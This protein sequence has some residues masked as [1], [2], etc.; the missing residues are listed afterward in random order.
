MDSIGKRIDKVIKNSN[1]SQK[2]FAEKIG[3]S[4]QAIG[5][6]INNRRFPKAEI[7]LKMKQTFNVSVDWLLT[8]KNDT[9]KKDTN[10]VSEPREVYKATPIVE[11]SP[12][13]KANC[14]V[15]DVKASAGFGSLM[16]SRT[17]LEELPAISLLNA[18]F[19]LNVA[20]QIEGDSM[21]NTIRHLDYVA[22]NHI[23]DIK[24]IKDGH[25]YIIIEKGN[26]PT[27]KR[28]YKEKGVFRIV[29]D[30]PTY[31]EYILGEK[32]IVAIF[33][34]FQRFSSDFRNYFDEVRTDVNELK[35]GFKE[36]KKQF[37]SLER[38]LK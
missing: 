15:A 1:L 21:H 11:I 38:R 9:E 30:N 20:F 31:P 5:N 25:V 7:L 18:P 8:G 13:A 23:T 35:N 24:D 6:Y 12:E 37:S 3:I 26:G 34:A 4:E 10:Q 22:G 17:R 32:D 16:E 36:L 2:D 29:S 28:V 19:G 33:K 27:C 14:L